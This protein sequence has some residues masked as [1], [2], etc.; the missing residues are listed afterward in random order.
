MAQSITLTDPNI[1]LD[2]QEE[3]T[4]PEDVGDAESPSGEDYSLPSKRKP[5]SFYFAFLSLVIMVLLVSLDST[6]LGV[7]VPVS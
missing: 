3:K 1:K 2:Y 6:A 4:T 7:A 5:L